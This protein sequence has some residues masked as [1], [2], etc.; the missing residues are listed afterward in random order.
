MVRQ[1]AT[2]SFRAEPTMGRLRCLRDQG[3]AVHDPPRTRI[4]V[5][6]LITPTARSTRSSVRRDD[7]SPSVG[8]GTTRRKVPRG[9]GASR[10]TSRPRSSNAVAGRP[11]PEVLGSPVGRSPV[12]RLPRGRWAPHPGADGP[13]PSRPSDVACPR[14]GGGSSGIWSAMPTPFAPSGARGPERGLPALPGR[15]VGPEVTGCFDLARC[16]TSILHET[17]G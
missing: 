12:G 16:A 6:S 15:A 8:L 5:P 4:E 11:R 7:V 1:E 14:G 9:V 3:R 10:P 2:H 13:T 17:A